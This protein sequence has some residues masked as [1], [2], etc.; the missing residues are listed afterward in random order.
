MDQWLSAQGQFCLLGDTW[1][2]LETYLDITVG[3]IAAGIWWKVARD[4]DKPFTRH[5]AAATV[6]R[7]PAPHVASAEVCKPDS[8]HASLH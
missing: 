4:A 1:Q 3:E 2:Y 7:Y 8:G 6:R 5:G